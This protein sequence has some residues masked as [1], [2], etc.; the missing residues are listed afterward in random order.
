MSTAQAA[1]DPHI[2]TL[3]GHAYTFNGLG[4]FTLV[5]VKDSTAEVQ[6]K[7]AQAKNTEGEYFNET[8]SLHLK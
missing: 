6:V 5:K 7:T 2:E 8:K 4:S 3:D 1:G